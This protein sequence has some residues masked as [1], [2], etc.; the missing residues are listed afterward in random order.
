M[1][2]AT[3]ERA[4]TQIKQAWQNVET[5]LA[6]VQC[7]NLFNLGVGCVD[8]YFCSLSDDLYVSKVS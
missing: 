1:M 2:T 6:V 4:Y 8:T 3:Y 7:L 5:V